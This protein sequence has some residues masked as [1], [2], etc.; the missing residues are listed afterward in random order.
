MDLKRI[1]VILGY[2][3]AVIWVVLGIVF[4]AIGG[5]QS[6]SILVAGIM[7]G[8]LIGGGTYFAGKWPMYGGI[9]LIILSLLSFYGVLVAGWLALIGFI[10][11]GA[12]V[13]AAGILFILN[14][15][16]SQ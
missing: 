14:E 15:R 1:A 5:T 10:L 13:L 2:V 4:Y 11:F 3:W 12:P 6:G 7:M 8:L 9:L 16:R